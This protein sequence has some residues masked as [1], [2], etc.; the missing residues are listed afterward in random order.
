MKLSFPTGELYLESRRSEYVVI[1]RGDVVLTTRSEKKAITKYNELR[2]AFATNPPP[3]LTSQER[4]TLLGKL[5]GDRLVDDNHY[6]PQQE[7]AKRKQSS[8]T[9]G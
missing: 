1:L 9:F 3:E 2:K 7:S 5:V 6:R 8:R 4:A